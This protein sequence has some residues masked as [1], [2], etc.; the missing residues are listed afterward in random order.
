MSNTGDARPTVTLYGRHGCH[1]CSDAR[2]LLDRLA[3]RYV[4]NV[5]E[6]DVDGDAALLAQYDVAVP[7]VVLDGREL[8]RAPIDAGLLERHLRAVLDNRRRPSA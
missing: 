4:F 3:A 1:L 6:V 5:N 7:V 2:R 8:A